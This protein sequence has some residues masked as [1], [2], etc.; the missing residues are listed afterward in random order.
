MAQAIRD[1]IAQ[2]AA[3]NLTPGEGQTLAAMIEVQR[4]VIE[5]EEHER[6]LTDLERKQGLRK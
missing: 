5:T 1:V 3:G 4:R 6:R 2:V